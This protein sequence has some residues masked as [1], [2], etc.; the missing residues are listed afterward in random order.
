M[1][2]TN[3]WTYPCQ[4]ISKMPFTSFNIHSKRPQYAPH[5]WTVPAYGQ[6]IQYAPLPDA[7]PPA[8]AAE[9]TR[10]Q[11]IVGTLLYNARAVYPTLLVP[12]S[13]LAS[14]LSTATATTIK[15]VS[16]LF[17]YCSTLPEVN[18]RYFASDM[19]LKIHSD[20]SYLSEPKAKSR[21][22]GYFYLGNKSDS[23]MKPLYNG[24][25]LCHT[26]FLKHVV[27]SV[28]EAEFGALF[29]NA[30]EG[31]VTRTTL[32]E[33][34]HNQDA[35]DLTTDNTTSDVIINNTV[36]Q[37]RSKAMDMRLYSVKDRVEQEQFNVGWAPGDTKLGDYFTKHYFPAHHKHMIPYYL[38]DKHSPMIRH[39]TRL[40]ILRGCVDIPPSS[41]PDRALSALNYGLTPI[42]NL[43]HSRHER[44]PIACAHI[45]GNSNTH[46]SQVSYRNLLR[47]QYKQ[48]CNQCEH[49]HTQVYHTLNT[50]QLH[51]NAPY[52]HLSASVSTLPVERIN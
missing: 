49:S 33:M 3:M 27:S 21:I 43:S 7:A 28:A 15:A 22:G 51:L 2:P 34:G 12:L 29:V 36:Q 50:H 17:D 6:R 19:Q 8:T 5:N 4:D 9:I 35:T 48:V 1:T 16:H 52:K 25:L 42:C 39:N 37:K 40:S 10:A 31:T 38:H 46:L 20:A 47:S 30:K 26:T 24:P 14:Q 32:S 11:A 18:I 45:T 41:Q 44:T 23:R 13:A